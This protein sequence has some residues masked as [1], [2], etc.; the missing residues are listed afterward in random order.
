MT[1][2]AIKGITELIK[3][4]DG[5]RL[6]LNLDFNAMM[7]FERDFLLPLQ[8]TLDDIQEKLSTPD[9]PATDTEPA[10]EGHRATNED[11]FSYCQR[12]GIKTETCRHEDQAR[13]AYALTESWREDNPS[14]QMS[15]QAFRRLLPFGTDMPAWSRAVTRV[16]AQQEEKPAAK[17]SSGE[18]ADSV[19]SSSS[20][21]NPPTGTA[22]STGLPS[23]GDEVAPTT[24]GDSPSGNSTL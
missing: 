17:N 11:V 12:N 18:G 8:Q 6:E 4:R 1:G 9:R 13:W 7:A 21:A 23:S 2:Q 5:S 10:Y 19:P 14:Q 22:S 20:D 3:L 16:M 24:S 15:F